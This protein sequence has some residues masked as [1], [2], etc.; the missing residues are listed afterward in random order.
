MSS[1]EPRPEQMPW[2]I[3]SSAV[4][5]KSSKSVARSEDSEG[6]GVSSPKTKP[7]LTREGGAPFSGENRGNR[8]HGVRC[9]QRTPENKTANREI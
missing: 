8:G 2:S 3:L 7:R 6:G 5:L 4:E 9:S 1:L